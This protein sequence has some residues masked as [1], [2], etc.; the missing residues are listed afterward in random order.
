MLDLAD[1]PIVRRWESGAVRLVEDAWL[2]LESG[3]EIRFAASEGSPHR[4]RG[5]DYWLIPA[6][7]ATA[8]IEWPVDGDRPEALPPHGVKHRYAPLAVLVFRD[9]SFER[10]HDYRH[11]YRPQ[12]M[13]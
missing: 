8:S 5:G 1:H 9:G 4:Y 12:L 13:T 6:R 2:P 7:T 11:R 3:L 10:A